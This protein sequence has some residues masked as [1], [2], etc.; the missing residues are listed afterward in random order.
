M[1]VNTMANSNVTSI[2]AAMSTVVRNSKVNGTFSNG[3]LIVR[4]NETWG[5]ITSTASSIQNFIFSPGAS[6]GT[7]PRLDVFAQ[8]YEL[9]RLRRATLR[10][11]TSSG[12]NV[13]GAVYLGIDFDA[14]D[15]STTVAQVQ[16]LD[17]RIRV[18]VW[19]NG[20]L[21]VPI[22]KVNLRNG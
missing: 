7:L 2:P 20:L 1:R 22:D 10:Y 16:S 12:S 11:A 9:W 8:L 4:G 21:P 13:N 15:L 6:T 18:S 5:L 17:P 3:S 14:S 19:E